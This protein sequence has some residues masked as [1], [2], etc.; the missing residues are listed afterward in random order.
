MSGLYD[1]GPV[2]C[3]IKANF[4]QLWRN[5]FIIEEGMLEI[6]ATMLTPEAVFK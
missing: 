6:D 4:I 1:F 2:G 3:A 5:H